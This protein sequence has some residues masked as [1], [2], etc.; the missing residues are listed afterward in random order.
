[1][2]TLT[3]FL[4]IIFQKTI[5]IALI[6]LFANAYITDKPI[7]EIIQT[8]AITLII[9]STFSIFFDTP[10]FI[11]K[12]ANILKDIVIEKDFLIEIDPKKKK[13]F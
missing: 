2:Q 4:E 12:I 1:M 11:E 5:I 3:E 9:S 8:F 13:E 6:L 10:S 7:H